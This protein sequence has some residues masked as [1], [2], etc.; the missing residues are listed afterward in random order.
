MPPGQHVERRDHQG[1]VG[2]E[3]LPDLMPHLLDVAHHGEHGVDGLDQHPLV[4]LPA[5][6]HLQVGWVALLGVEPGVAKDHGMALEG[7]DQRVEPCVVGV[8]GCPGPADDLAQ[9]VDG[10]AQFPPTIHRWLEMPGAAHCSGLR[11]LRTGWISS[12]P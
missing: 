7:I 1:E 11:P 8:R 5:L 6:A 3:I 4:V 10:K 2:L 12:T 9:V